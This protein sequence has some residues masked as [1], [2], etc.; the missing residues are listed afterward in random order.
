M[1]RLLAVLAAAL[2]AVAVYAVAAPA[3]EQ[4]VTPKQF[5]ALSKKVKNVQN[6]LAAFENCVTQAIPVARYGDPN[7]NYGYLYDTS[8]GSQIYTTGLDVADE[9]S[10][11]YVLIT[12]ADCASVF[13]SGKKKVAIAHLRAK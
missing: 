13:N 3:S 6:E 11:T 8:T 9:G 7:G 12:N 1:N 10:S 2:V 5:A 4:A